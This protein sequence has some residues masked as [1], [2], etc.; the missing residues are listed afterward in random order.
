MKDLRRLLL[1][2]FILTTALVS[3]QKK[4]ITGKVIDKA[5]GQPLSGAT[6]LVDKAK[7]GIA[8]KDDGT[9]TISISQAKSTLVFSY[10]GYVT[11]IIPVD[12]KTV[13]NV[14]LVQSTAATESEV[15][16]IGYGTQKR[17]LVTGAVSKYK[18]D[19]LDETPVSRLDQALQG[20]MAG[21]QVQ[22]VSSEAGAAPKIN[23]RG[24]SSINA[25]ASPLVVVDGQPV[26]DG[27]AFVNMGDVESVE[28]LKDAASAAIYGSRGASGVILITTKSGKAETPKYNF[29]YSLG[30]KRDYKRYEI[31]SST[32]YVNNL[33]AE[34]ALRYLDSAAYCVG[35]TTAQRT[36]FGNNKGNLVTAGERAEYVIEQTMRDGQGTDWQSESLRPGLFQNAQLSVSG[37]KKEV[38]YF[39]SGSYQ[40]DEGMMNKSD[41]ERATLRTKID[42]Q[43]S[44]KVKLSLNLNPSFSRKETPSENFTNFYR[45]P[46]FLPVYHNN[47]TAATVNTVAQWAGIRPGDFAQPRHFTNIIYS[48]K[49]PD[50]STWAPGTV[51]DP[52]GSAQNNPKSSV[53]NQDINASEYRVQSSADLGINILPGLDF[54]SLASLYV[55]Y[56]TGL[57]YSVKNAQADGVVSKGVFSTGTNIDLLTENTFTYKKTFKDHSINVLGGFTAQKTT[58]NK[59][60]TTGLDFPSDDIRTLNNASSIDKSGTSGTKVQIG[61]I[62]YLGRVSYDFKNKYLLSVSFRTDGSSYFAPG[63]KWGTFPS[64]SVGWVPTQEKFLENVKWLN[65]LKFRGSYGATGNNRTSDFA[66]LDLLSTGNYSFGAGTGVLSN[67]QVTSTTNIANP[68]VTWERTFQTNFGVDITVL[69]NRISLSVDAYTS[70]TERLLLQQSVQAFAGVTQ[71]YNNIGS[72][73]NKGVEFELSTTNVITRNFKWSTS[74]NLSTNKNEIL[75]LGK[76]AYLHN[77]GERGEVYQNRVGDPLIQFLGFKTDGVW[78]SRS[79]IDAAIAKGLTSSL[80]NVF[81]PGGLKIV[82]VNGDN[83]IDNNDRTIIGTPY[84]K[85][86]W[87]ITNT[88]SYKA[89]DASFTLQGVQGGNVINGDPNYNESKRKVTAY[90]QNRWVSPNN[91]GDG[92][93]PY[94]TVGFNWMLTDYVVEDASYFSLREI[95][96]G[97]KLPAAVS[98]FVKLNSLRVYASAQNLF[99]HTASGFRA[100][101]P[102][103]RAQTGPYSSAL[104]D[105]YQRGSFPIQRTFVFGVDIDF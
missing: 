88:F 16:V 102:E 23:I 25:G 91:P 34:A 29:K 49:M 43:L 68:T 36:A 14:F 90:N 87:G 86:T 66:Y 62:S 79:D 9:Y 41:F 2:P 31:W 80:S 82:D 15:V 65:R 1:L 73:K 33:Y 27:L 104:L 61:L 59:D 97:Y 84:P 26:P 81:I 100:L 57:N 13:I 46:T 56:S 77:S 95:N 42:M 96:I 103:G 89:F 94:S 38:K 93:T 48:G 64:V 40:R 74:A 20:K 39:I 58:I 6:V 75:E 10:L 17:G 55:N 54:K 4:V 11:Q 22:N 37:G 53:L 28:V 83:V 98:K 69:K 5:T 76:E 44:K 51:S 60:Q 19:K 63:N 105:G 52:F 85:F 7:T 24:I 101:N 32:Q 72:L 18:N 71:Y 35:F 45:Y 8:T 67:G 92:K 47:L 78:L 3:A 70:K 99:F 12:N 50:G 21:V 30:Q